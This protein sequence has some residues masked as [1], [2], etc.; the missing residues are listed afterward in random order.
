MLFNKLSLSLTC[1]VVESFSSYLL[2]GDADFLCFVLFRGSIRADEVL[3]EGF[4]TTE[5][6]AG[7]FT[8]PLVDSLMCTFTN[9]ASWQVI[10]GQGSWDVHL[11]NLAQLSALNMAWWNWININLL[12]IFVPLASVESIPLIALVF[13]DVSTVVPEAIVP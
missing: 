12:T 5:E 7:G 8:L 2:S 1:C 11:L 4:G 6:S 13:E 9:L 10:V 3:L